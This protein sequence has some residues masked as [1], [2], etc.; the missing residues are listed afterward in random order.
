MSK[1]VGKTPEC[2]IQV[3][4][5]LCIIFLLLMYLLVVNEEIHHGFFQAVEM[6]IHKA[7]FDMHPGMSASKRRE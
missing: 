5:Q 7:C 1:K 2:V 3:T 6:S 4:V